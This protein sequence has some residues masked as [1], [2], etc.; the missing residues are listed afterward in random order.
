[1]ASYKHFIRLP[2]IC[3]AFALSG[4]ADN[5]RLSRVYQQWMPTTQSE[6]AWYQDAGKMLQKKMQH[7]ALQGSA[8]KA[9]NVILFVGD[10][11][12]MSTITAARI[13]QGQLAGNSGEENFLSFEHFP[14]SGFS[15]TYNVNQQTPDSA[16]TMSAMMT[17]VKTDAGVLAV[18]E[19]ASRSDCSS[20][21]SRQLLSVLDMA[22]L[23]GKSTGIVT[24]A[25]ITHATPAAAYA[26]SVERN[27]EDDTELS[28]RAKIEGC[29]DIATQLIEFQYGNGIDVI[30]GGGRKHFF[31]QQLNGNRNDNKNLVQQWQDTYPQGSY[32]ENRQDLLSASLESSSHLFG[33]FNKSHMSYGAEKSDEPSLT[34]MSD[35]A[36]KRLQKNDKG[37]LLIIE[38]GRIDH[39]HHAGN[40]Y[41]A[42]HETL[43]LSNAVDSVLAQVDLSET[44]VIVTADHIHVMT[45][46][47]YP[48]RG[49]PILGKV[50]APGSNLPE[51][52]D[53]GLPYTTLS[54]MNG[55]GMNDLGNEGDAD[56]SKKLAINVGRKDISKIN[57]QAPGY[58]QEA[59]IPRHSETH[60]G[61]DVGVYATGPGAQWLTG[62]NEQN[63]IFHVIAQSLFN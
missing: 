63:M 27:W 14:F 55:R 16:G 21:E 9:K 37:Y 22:E 26:K 18:D 24:T 17:G 32:V 45:F 53:D 49:N 19:L 13:L 54:Y 50:I 8:S 51:L 1:M 61:E 30:L 25:R 44:L 42:L 10:G 2:I 5:P 20:G 57:T 7:S 48:K 58:H 31:P 59:L 56:R 47:G 35:V 12:G 60:G 11:M 29:K 52:A 34:Q 39:G 33:L 6:N 46:A 15:K 43:A 3:T 62:V 36:L 4:C 41:N 28:A 40:A 38:S 23:V